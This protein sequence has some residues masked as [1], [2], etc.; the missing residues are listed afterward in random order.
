MEN[1]NRITASE[2][3]QTSIE[4]SSAVSLATQPSIDYKTLS[5][6]QLRTFLKSRNIKANGNKAELVKRLRRNDIARCAARAAH[7]DAN[8]TSAPATKASGGDKEENPF[9]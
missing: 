1:I 8:T 3:S 6:L 9:M 5:L 7:I 4:D 2:P